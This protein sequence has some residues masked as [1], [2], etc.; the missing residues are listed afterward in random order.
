MELGRKPR[1]KSASLRYWLVGVVD[2]SGRAGCGWGVGAG[3]WGAAGGVRS[4]TVDAV[5]GCH[6]VVDG[7]DDAFDTA[8]A[9]G[10]RVGVD[11][12]G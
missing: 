9:P 3:G 11:T 10:A 7:D 1:R 12:V 8:P 4:S 6:A 5:H 2:R